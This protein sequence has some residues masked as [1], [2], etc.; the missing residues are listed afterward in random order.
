MALGKS[1]HSPLSGALIQPAGLAG[2]RT[3]LTDGELEILTLLAQGKA[4][5]QV[6]AALDVSVRT[7]EAD[8]AS[9]MRKLDLRSL[10]ELNLLRLSQSDGENVAQTPTDSSVIVLRNVQE[11]VSYLF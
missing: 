2:H 8:R 7:V 10:S 11:I 9:L 5:K 3:T 4:N 6:A 1:F